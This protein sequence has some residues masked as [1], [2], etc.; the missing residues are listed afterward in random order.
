MLIFRDLVS[1]EFLFVAFLFGGSYKMNP[2]LRPINSSADLTLVAALAGIG[3]AA[4][5]MVLRPPLLHTKIQLYIA[6]YLAFL[7]WA[8]LSYAL[9][10]TGDY[11]MLKIQKFGVMCTWALVCP[12]FFMT[13][14]ERVNRFFRLL[15]AMA[16]FAGLTALISGAREG[17]AKNLGMFG[18][19]ADYQALGN[20][21]GWGLI[22]LL[23]N[24]AFAD[25]YRHQL[26]FAV[27]AALLGLTLFLSGAR[28]SAVGALLGATFI[29][30]L[31]PKGRNLFHKAKGLFVA[32]LCI[33]VAGI[34]LK[35]MVL[36]D[37]HMEKA[38]S[39]ILALVSVGQEEGW[40]P[41]K[42]NRPKLL[43]AALQQW[44]ESPI[45]GGGFGSYAEFAMTN[46]ASEV[47]WP[48]NLFLELLCELGIIGFGLGFFLLLIPF[49]TWLQNRNLFADRFG[50]T[51]MA[52]LIFETFCAMVSRD[53][54]D[55]RGVFVFAGM[56]MAYFAR[57]DPSRRAVTVLPACE[58]LVEHSH[59]E[60]IAVGTEERR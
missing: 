44:Q 54:P 52:L 4:F 25:K 56:V 59:S 29:I 23:A 5:T 37:M 58:R 42:E 22:V 55:D 10:P 20:T 35:M 33:A 46:Y 49:W 14:Q 41:S 34:G 38:E 17:T 16:L 19:A 32:L 28:Q 50:A 7:A 48:H 21:C 45:T 1:L 24:L 36:P 57:K 31:A 6:L 9:N 2:L 12:L 47:R 60:V 43:E 3:C 13:D 18:A 15:V 53:L 51:I 39:R 26:A 11:A 27:G 8:L 40:D 30:F